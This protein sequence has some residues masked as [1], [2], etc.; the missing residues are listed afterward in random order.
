M[1]KPEAR[2]FYEIEAIRN[3]WSARELERQ[4]C[5]LLYERLALSRDKKG[6]ILKKVIGALDW[7]RPEIVRDLTDA[8]IK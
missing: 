4:I 2:A 7:S 8:A 5:S 3:N 1:D 6:L